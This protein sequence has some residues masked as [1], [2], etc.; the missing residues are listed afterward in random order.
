MVVQQV[1][2]QFWHVDGDIF[3]GQWH[4][5]KANGYL[6]VAIRLKRFTCYVKKNQSSSKKGEQK[7]QMPF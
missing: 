7:S 5:D 6:A 4:D 2:L 1:A 3:E